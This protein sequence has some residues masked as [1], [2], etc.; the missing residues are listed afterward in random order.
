M[1]A[2]ISSKLHQLPSGIWVSG[3][4][5]AISYPDEGNQECFAV[6]DRSFWFRHRNE[7]L[8]WL[9]GKFPVQGV[10]ADV[11][12]GNGFVA[13]MIQETGCPVV[14]FEPGWEGASNARKRG[15]EDVVCSTFEDAELAEQSFAG[16]GIFDVLEHIEDDSGFLKRI[17]KGLA[18]GG[19]MFVTVPAHQWL[20]S[21]DDV[22][23]GHFRRY[24]RSGLQSVLRAAGLEP[25][26]CTHFFRI[27]IPPLF[28][29][30]TLPSL[31]GIR[32]VSTEHTQTAHG[33]EKSL[34]TRFIEASCR[35]ELLRLQKQSVGRLGTSIVA[36]A[37]RS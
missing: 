27:L 36:A 11:G 32:R 9:L 28:A 17:T 25:V 14:L 34:I 30:R 22:H 23:A 37:R 26:Y 8:R 33:V 10:F 18:K 16:M 24:S 2:S 19:Y 12:G 3:S 29:A 5:A 21:E 4:Q 13:R 7:V 1:I 35:R 6:E 15:V 31:L 20:W